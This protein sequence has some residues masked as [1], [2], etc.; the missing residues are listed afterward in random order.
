MKSSSSSSRPAGI[1][2]GRQRIMGCNPN[3]YA[4]HSANTE[5]RRTVLSCSASCDTGK[6]VQ[7]RA[8]LPV[9]LLQLTTCYVSY[10]LGIAAGFSWMVT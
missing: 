9:G 8:G 1:L 6:A 5:L 4:P 2:Q 3:T 7:A 10:L